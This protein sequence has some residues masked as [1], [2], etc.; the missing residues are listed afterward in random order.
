MGKDD[1]FCNND[2][3]IVTDDDPE[4][5]AQQLRDLSAKYYDGESTVSDAEFD[6]L[7]DRLRQLDPGNIFLKEVGA[8]VASSA[9][10]KKKH[11][12]FMGSLNKCNTEEEFAHWVED[13]GNS[14]FLTEKADGS[15]VVA[16]YKDGKLISII[17]RG[18]GLEG[19]DITSNAVQL[20]NVK[21]ELPLP[22]SG[23]LRGEAMMLLSTYTNVFEP[24]GYRNARNGA[25]G[26]LRDQKDSGLLKHL[27]VKWF[28]VIPACSV[29]FTTESTKFE[30]LEALGLEHIFGKHI[31]GGVLSIWDI[32]QYYVDSKRASLDYEIDGLVVKV[33]NLSQQ[34][35]LGI[36][37]GRPKGAIA[38]KFPS[39]GKETTLLDVIWQRGKTGRFTPVAVLKPTH[40]SGVTIVN[41]SLHN[42]DQINKLGIAIGDSVIVQR[43]NDVIPQ[44]VKLVNKST[45]RKEIKPPKDCFVCGIELVHDGAY[46]TCFNSDCGGNVYG[47]LMKWV[48][49]VKIMQ[50]GP[51]MVQLLIEHGIT[52]P[53]ELYNATE[54]EISVALNSEKLGK[55]VFNNIQATRTITLDLFL[56]AFGIPSLG[57]TNGKR[58]AQHF[59]TLDNVMLASKEDVGSLPGIK[60]NAVKIHKGL[61]DK[62]DLILELSK[63][64][65]IKE[66][67]VQTTEGKLSGKSFCITG[68]LSKPREEVEAWI[69]Q[70][71]GEVKSGI[72]KGLSYLIT[73]EPGSG[74]S[75]NVKADKLGVL[76]ITEDELYSLAK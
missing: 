58:I 28:D 10:P 2:T 37:S 21:Q 41:A 57:T 25:T 35:A 3:F 48:E 16:S 33:D 74:S 7:V 60:T 70:N 50:L 45:E 19:E 5:L 39:V 14:F 42:M 38:I 40:V 56:S 15:T 76:K 26:K 4:T 27:E 53:A 54:V 65:V 46:L 32:F 44:V 12:T 69:R 22:F 43:N 8:P 34:S 1:I 17:T 59:K 9:W 68:A 75:K 6:A 13:K 61:Q 49:E 55:K 72:S 52:D 11:Q 18:D 71:G 29:E 73:Q 64:L 62:K 23:E 66:T 20:K 24:L 47:Q 67:E 63:I 30:F 36:V 31:D 51:A